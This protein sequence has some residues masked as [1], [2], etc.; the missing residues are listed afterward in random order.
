MRLLI[1]VVAVVLRGVE[2]ALLLLPV[3]VVLLPPP[4]VAVAAAGGGG[5]TIQSRL[6]EKNRA[7]YSGKK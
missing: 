7:F 5:D 1:A 6:S 2:G 3:V 4:V